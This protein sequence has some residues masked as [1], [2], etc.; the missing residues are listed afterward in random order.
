MCDLTFTANDRG[1]EPLSWSCPPFLLIFP[2]V[3][4]TVLRAIAKK[5]PHS[6][7]LFACVG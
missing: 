5:V 6:G 7:V 1:E 3:N 4:R 2:K